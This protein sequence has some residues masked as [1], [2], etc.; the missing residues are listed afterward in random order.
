VHAAASRLGPARLPERGPDWYLAELR[1]V[2]ESFRRSFGNPALSEDERRTLHA[3]LRQCDVLESRWDGIARLCEGVPPTLVHGDL[4]PKNT[5]VRASAAGMALFA[6]DWE[7]A[8]WGSPAIDLAQNENALRPDLAAW[9]SAVR[10]AFVSFVSDETVSRVA[11]AGRV[12][13]LIV[14]MSWEKGNLAGAWPARAVRHLKTY[15]AV[16]AECIQS[17]RWE[18]TWRPA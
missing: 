9:R 15:H 7:T 10:H 12:F 14:S 5:R 8:S 1:S 3:V 2:A 18:E 4:A 13:R 16:L 11:E 17:A 6:L